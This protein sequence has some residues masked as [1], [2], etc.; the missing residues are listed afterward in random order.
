VSKLGIILEFKRDIFFLKSLR[1]QVSSW[2]VLKRK[3]FTDESVFY[4][5]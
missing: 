3:C 1:F 4:L 5:L 2:F